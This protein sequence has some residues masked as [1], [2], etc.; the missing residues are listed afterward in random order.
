[1]KTWSFLLPLLLAPAPAAAQVVY[2]APFSDFRI[3]GGVLLGGAHSE[4]TGGLLGANVNVGAFIPLGGNFGLRGGLTLIS[5][6]NLSPLESKG[7]F[8]LSAG[9]GPDVTIEIGDGLWGIG[10]AGGAEYAFFGS[11][12]FPEGHQDLTGLLAYEELA[13][14]RAIR[15]GLYEFGLRA[16]QFVGGGH[17][18]LSGGVFFRFSFRI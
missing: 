2:E 3:S 6:Q 10:L 15:I 4:A 17:L 11:R 1:M 12:E 18:V 5:Q 9:G 16:D 14:R 7:V 8:L 13:L